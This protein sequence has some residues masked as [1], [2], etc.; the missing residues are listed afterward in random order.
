[1][2]LIDKDPMTPEMKAKRASLTAKSAFSKALKNKSN[3]SKYTT[4]PL[5]KMVPPKGKERN[6]PRNTIKQY[7]DKG[8]KPAT[9]S[10]TGN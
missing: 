7:G 4:N 3:V 6:A 8:Y 10:G 9:G 2:H 1:M 5:L